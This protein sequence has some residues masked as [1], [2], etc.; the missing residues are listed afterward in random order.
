MGCNGGLMDKAFK[1]AETNAVQ[2]EANYPY[3]SGKGQRGTCETS[4][5]SGASLKVSSYADVTTNDADALKAQLEKGP[6]SVAIE[7][8]KAVFQNYSSGI[9]SGTACGTNLDHGVLCVGWGSE[10]GTEYWL[11]KNSWGP[12]WGDNGY[13]KMAVENTN[14]KGT[15]G[16]LS[17]PP[18]QP[19]TN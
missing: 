10:N 8:D 1:Y 14:A 17:G 4:K 6:V 11:V 19:V 15:C 9:L 16:I 13:I 7:A 3:T 2:T 5:L 18:S 12:T